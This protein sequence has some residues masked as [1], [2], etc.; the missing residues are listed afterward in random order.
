MDLDKLRKKIE[1][2]EKNTKS[3]IE[4]FR[5]NVHKKE[6]KEIS[7][8]KEVFEDEFIK[9]LKIEVYSKEPTRKD[10]FILKFAEL[11]KKLGLFNFLIEFAYFHEKIVSEIQH[12]LN[13]SKT[14][15]KENFKIRTIILLCFQFVVALVLVLLIKIIKIILIHLFK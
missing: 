3:N 12:K 2:E 10:K 7:E 14:D 9:E 13:L 4:I 6:I 11:I 1:E 8:N 5:D 15:L